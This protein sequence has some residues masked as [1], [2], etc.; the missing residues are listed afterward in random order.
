[1][2]YFTQ[3]VSYYELFFNEVIYNN[4]FSINVI[5]NSYSVIVNKVNN[6]GLSCAKLS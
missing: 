4:V 6:L 3:S 2:L 5:L 1:M